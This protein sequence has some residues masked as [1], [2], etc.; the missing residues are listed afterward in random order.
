MKVDTAG[1]CRWGATGEG[2]TCSEEEAQT[3]R[4]LEGE[5]AAIHL[6]SESSLASMSLIAGPDW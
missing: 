2:H 5:S 4:K 1:P 3:L 6:V